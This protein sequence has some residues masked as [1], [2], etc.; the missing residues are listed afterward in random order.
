MFF[1]CV[2][3][4]QGVQSKVG[5]VAWVHWRVERRTKRKRK[6]WTQFMIACSVISFS[7]STGWCQTRHRLYLMEAKLQNRM[8]RQVAKFITILLVTFIY[9]IKKHC[10]RAEIYWILPNVTETHL[11]ETYPYEAERQKISHSSILSKSLLVHNAI[12]RRRSMWGS[13][14]DVLTGLS[15]FSTTF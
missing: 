6:W 9:H 12:I 1:N 11:F 10:Y 7:S 13:C 14:H 15:L 8:I 5:M 4:Q 2:E 3:L